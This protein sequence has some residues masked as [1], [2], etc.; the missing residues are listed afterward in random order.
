MM[1]H[2]LL[3][4]ACAS[5]SV[6]SPSRAL[7]SSTFDD[8]KLLRIAA[9]QG[10]TAIVE[11]C[12]EDG[13]PPDSADDDGITPLMRAAFSGQGEVVEVLLRYKANPRLQ[14]HQGRSAYIWAIAGRDLPILK[15]LLTSDQGKALLPA[16][17][18]DM[19]SY[20][21]QSGGKDMP[22]LLRGMLTASSAPV[23]AAALTAAPTWVPAPQPA[24][25]MPLAPP[26]F[27][28]LPTRVTP[29]PVPPSMR[30]PL[31]PD[32]PSVPPTMHLK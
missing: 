1:H 32:F 24:L 12:L 5:I 30:A 21:N 29:S 4:V 3:A 2:C 8:P 10:M 31:V 17:R 15:K 14:D 26:A 25:T 20:A 27:P 13:V 7:A 28:M 22:T 23:T 9:Q 11:A 19:I 18:D 6:F 16:E